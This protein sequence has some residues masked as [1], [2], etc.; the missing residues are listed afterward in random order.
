MIFSQ[1]NLAKFHVNFGVKPLIVLRQ[2]VLSLNHIHGLI[3][4]Y[5]NL[6]SNALFLRPGPPPLLN[7]FDKLLFHVDRT[8]VKM[9]W[10][11]F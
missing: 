2:K 9:C 8:F 6:I 1:I 5:L 7:S 4:N 3:T 10:C 11:V